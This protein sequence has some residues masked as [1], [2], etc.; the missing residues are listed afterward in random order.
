MFFT[1]DYI[2]ANELFRKKFIPSTSKNHEHWNKAS[3]K[4]NS[5]NT[6][7]FHSCFLVFES[8]L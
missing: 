8:S 5:L 6:K 3:K 7:I 1:D 4:E 2:I